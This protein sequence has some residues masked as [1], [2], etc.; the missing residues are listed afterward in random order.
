MGGLSF[1]IV[2]A[3]G[4]WAKVLPEDESEAIAALEREGWEPVW[5]S[6]RSAAEGYRYAAAAARCLQEDY[7]DSYGPRPMAGERVLYRSVSLPELSDVISRGAVSGRGNAFNEFDARPFAFFG[8]RVTDRLVFQ[9]EDVER[10]AM[11]A[12]QGEQVFLEFEHVLKQA[13]SA[14]ET[15][16][17]ACEERVRSGERLRPAMDFAEDLKLARVGSD[18]AISRLANGF[19]APQPE[20]KRLKARMDGFEERIAEL[21]GRYARMSESWM[22]EERAARESYPFTSAILETQPISHG[23]HYSH[24]FGSSGMGDDDEFGFHPDSVSLDDVTRIHLVRD[25]RTFD[26]AGPDRFESLRDEVDGFLA[27]ARRN[28]AALSA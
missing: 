4:R 1:H 20:L 12:L 15:F 11:T 14:A 19:F 25:G 10:Q 21:R 2:L 17:A 6:A 26:A 7:A 28:A 8:D 9:G 13:R 16:A 23:F 27:E 5:D 24:E 3:R 22:E 18:L